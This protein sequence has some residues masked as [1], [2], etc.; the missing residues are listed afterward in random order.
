[1]CVFVVTEGSK[2]LETMKDETIRH[3]R[4]KLGNKEAES[5]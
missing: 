1:M 4:K 2:K 5:I 3:V